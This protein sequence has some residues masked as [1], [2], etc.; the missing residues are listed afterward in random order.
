MDNKLT[1]RPKVLVL[2]STFPRWQQDTEPKF[3]YELSQ[4]LS[5]NHEIHVLAPHTRYAKTTEQMGN[6]KVF[7][8]RYFFSHFELLSYNGGILPNL[9]KRP[10]LLLLI[11]FF[12]I[13]QYFAVR[14]LIKKHNYEIVHAHW[15]IPQGV[16][17]YLSTLFSLKPK[18]VKLIITS[19]GG[20]LFSLNN[21]L[22]DLI[23]SKVL[24]TFDHIT[25]VSSIMKTKLESLGVASD[26]ITI[27]SMGVDLTSRFIPP[28]K[29]TVQNNI[30]FVGRLVEK[31]GLA[32]LIQAMPSILSEFP[33]LKLTIVG[34]GPLKSPLT[35]LSRELNIEENVNFV[36]A[37]KNEEIPGYLQKSL[38]AVIPSIVTKSGDQEGLGLTIVEALG[39]HCIVVAS[40]L[41]AI[42]DVISHKESGILV[43]PKCSEKIS[44]GI[45][46][47]LREKVLYKKMP[48]VGRQSVVRRFDWS[49]VANQYQ[50]IY[51]T[52]LTSNER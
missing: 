48:E 25:V 22:F 19:H 46:C 41:A 24:N 17:V 51:T 44:N 47:I 11:P 45:L 43:Q 38:I 2:T 20:D 8:F 28:N 30:I 40:D 14:K 23:R 12:F 42:R 26:K 16:C 6:L 29:H 39:C 37:V 4:R 9:K 52:L 36:G 18:T 49:V 5:E 35:Q 27:N 3:V 21:R 32:Y 10:A 34:D 33:E 13:G 1:R 31:K 7:R 15:I 50:E